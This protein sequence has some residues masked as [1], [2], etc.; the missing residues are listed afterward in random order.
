MLQD[1][2]FDLTVEILRYL[3][4]LDVLAIRKVG[5]RQ[6]A[7]S[8]WIGLVNSAC[9]EH[10]MFLGGGVYEDLSLAQLENA[11]TS[12]A[13]FLRRI[14][15]SPAL[16]DG[17]CMEP[18]YLKIYEEISVPSP[19]AFFGLNI[20]VVRGGR[21]LLTSS[22]D[23]IALW[24]LWKADG[25]TEPIARET[26]RERSQDLQVEDYW[27]DEENRLFVALI[28]CTLGGDTD[29]LDVYMIDVSVPSP[30]FRKVNELRCPGASYPAY[31]TR[32]RSNLAFTMRDDGVMG[33]WDYTTGNGSYIKDGCWETEKV[34]YPGESGSTVICINH[35]TIDIHAVPPLESPMPV[36]G[37]AALSY[38][39][40]KMFDPNDHDFITYQVPRLHT[41]DHSYYSVLSPTKKNLLTFMRSPLPVQASLNL[42][43]ECDYAPLPRGSYTRDS[44]V[45]VFEA[46]RHLKSSIVAVFA[47]R[48]RAEYDVDGVQPVCRTVGLLR[49]VTNNENDKCFDPA[50]GTFAYRAIGED[51]FV[52]V[53]IPTPST[54]RNGEWLEPQYLKIHEEIRF[55]SSV[56]TYISV[57]SVM[58][59]RGGRFLLT[60]T[61]G[62]LNL[63]DLWKA[64]RVTN[65]IARKAVRLKHVDDISLEDYWFDENHIFAAV[66]VY[67]TDGK[68][69]RLSVYAVDV[70]IP[71]PTFRKVNEL[72]CPGGSLPSYHARHRSRLAFSLAD[73]RLIGLWDYM[74]GHGVYMRDGDWETEE[75]IYPAGSASTLICINH[76][77][78]DVHEVPILQ[79]PIRVTEP[80]VSS[81]MPRSLTDPNYFGFITY[82][83]PQFDT[84]EQSF[85]SLQSP[86]RRDLLTFMRFAEPVK[87]P[88]T[89]PTGANYLP[90]PRG[91]HFGDFL[92][93]VFTS[94]SHQRPYSVV[95]AFAP[96]QT[97]TDEMSGPERA[98]RIAGLLHGVPINSTDQCFDPTSGT[99]VYRAVG[100]DH[101]TAR[102]ASYLKKPALA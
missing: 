13:R 3:A 50:S 67:A 53:C 78:I 8:L 56:Q 99:M 84:P 94:F 68:P 19:R 47:P 25:N 97:P 20:L 65:P 95:A 27:Y 52:R 85:H 30:S 76:E 71:M 101:D 102:I 74:T 15:P 35:E 33:I 28:R 51:S 89:L 39:S 45:T 44:L 46:A 24:D 88:L 59:V 93:I 55:L 29:F 90:L 100:A 2:P 91:T 92:A 10:D 18:T 66:A 41:P 73:E 72:S 31:H 5:D 4:P 62:R 77:S 16:L 6:H 64:T 26:V 87:A 21:F 81:S 1:V 36:R 38:R 96:S 22:E 83:V 80:A 48:S 82:Q 32:H 54:S 11:A 14:P 42:P 7:A 86:N 43:K 63:W 75:M 49:G 17:R 23:W 37:R 60:T 9:A 79:A 98:C 57:R 70:S 12:P 69:D 61:K 58:L 34:V 40:R